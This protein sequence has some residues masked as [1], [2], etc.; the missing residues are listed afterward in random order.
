MTLGGHMD[1]NALRPLRALLR[2]L[3]AMARSGLL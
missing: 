2:P 3:T 1:P